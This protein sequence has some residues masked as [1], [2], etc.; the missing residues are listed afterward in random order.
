[1][2]AYRKT[3]VGW[4]GVEVKDGAVTQVF[5]AE[6]EEEDSAPA[7]AAE[8]VLLEEAFCQLEAY[9]DGK[10]KVFALPLAPAGTPFQRRVWAV[11]E[12]IP[13][14]ETWSY[15]RVATAAGNPQATR[16]VGMANNRNPIA[17]V[18]PCHRVIGK[19]GTLVGYGGGLSRK[20]WLLELEKGGGKA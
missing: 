9:L 16:A 1:M 7:A 2:L 5:F 10:L 13:Y 15:Q 14:G 20:A 6:A 12:T 4:I 18:I 17:I 19:D 8:K 3:R 11:L